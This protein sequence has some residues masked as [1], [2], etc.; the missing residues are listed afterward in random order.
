[1][2]RVFA[3]FALRS[4]GEVGLGI[5]LSWVQEQKQKV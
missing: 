1:M 4:L 3:I 2:V 5:N